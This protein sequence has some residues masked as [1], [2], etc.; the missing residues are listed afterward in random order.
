MRNF[1]HASRDYGDMRRH[2]S[3]WDDRK[4]EAL[5]A[6]RGEPQDADLLS[7][8]QDLQQLS[9]HAAPAPS[10]ALTAVLDGAASAVPAVV[11]GVR[12]SMDRRSGL[13]AVAVVSA[14]GLGMATWGTAANALPAPVQR[15]VASVLNSLTPFDFPEPADELEQPVVPATT[16]GTTDSVNESDDVVPVPT[17]SSG[18]D[19]ST[20]DDSGDNSG[21][22]SDGDAVDGGE[23]DSDTEGPNEAPDSSGSNSGPGSGTDSDADEP[24]P[25]P[26]PSESSSSGSGSGDD[27]APEPDADSDSDE[28]P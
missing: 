11:V 8:L 17:K 5:L 7:A 9:M 18:P 23:T 2:G 10:A 3:G 16:P 6:G 14:L 12:R 20:D 21:S 1:R 19:D 4:V 25:S 13:R 27:A 15:T 28:S 24:E 26:T 22:D